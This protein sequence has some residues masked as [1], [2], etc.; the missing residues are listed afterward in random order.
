MSKKNKL[1]EKF[2]SVPKDL[3]CEELV[4]I[5]AFFGYSELGTGKTVDQ[6]AGLETNTRTFNIHNLILQIL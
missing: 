2:L 3:T 4:K 5:L 1:V 6:G